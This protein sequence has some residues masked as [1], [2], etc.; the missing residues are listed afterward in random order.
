MVRRK[1][2][3]L[4]RGL[5]YINNP[6]TNHLVKMIGST[7]NISR[8][9]GG[10]RYYAVPKCK[11]NITCENIENHISSV[12]AQ[13]QI[14][15]MLLPS[16]REAYTSNVANQFGHNRPNELVELTQT[17]KNIDNEEARMARLLATQKIS[18]T[19]W[20][21]LWN[22]WQ[23]RRQMIRSTL[24]TLQQQQTVHIDNLD[25]A[26]S[27][28][29]KIS[30]LYNKL[31]FCDKK[32]LLQLIFERIVVNSDGEIIQVDLL[33]P[34]AYLMNICSEINDD[35]KAQIKQTKFV[36]ASEHCST[37]VQLSDPNDTQD[38]PSKIFFSRDTSDFVQF[39][40]LIRF[41][42]RTALENLLTNE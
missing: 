1:R 33:P 7:P 25:S 9:G 5:L 38:E 12:I 26:L 31:E 16:I 10:N 34:F 41:P 18:E 39:L 30:I 37:Q 22:D 17:L 21:Q 20:D 4:L 23:D 2:E 3:Y 32:E 24:R 11:I 27:I 14:D 6:S 29:A 8:K 19:V 15:E 40:D 28:I 42:Q 35:T 13:I 36:C